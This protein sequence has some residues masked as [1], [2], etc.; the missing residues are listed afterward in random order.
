[1]KI[2]QLQA[3]EVVFLADGAKHN[4]KIQKTNFSEAIPILD[5][6]HAIEHLADFCWLFQ[7]EQTG[8]YAYAKWRGML[9]KGDVF[10]VLEDMKISMD[11]SG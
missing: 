8:K 11:E 9:Y 5:F 4:W 3:K 10:Q 7:E 1:L 2:E 6:Y